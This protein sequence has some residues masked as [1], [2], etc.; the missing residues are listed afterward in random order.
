[1]S[2]RKGSLNASTIRRN[3]SVDIWVRAYS[4]TIKTQNGYKQRLKELET[5]DN[6]NGHES[7]RQVKIEALKQL[8]NN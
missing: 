8:I 6:C 1:M 4:A 3:E 2:R 5:W 7:E